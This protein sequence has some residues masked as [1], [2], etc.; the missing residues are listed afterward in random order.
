[1]KTHLVVP[2]ATAMLYACSSCSGVLQAGVLPWSDYN[3]PD[4]P[5]PVYNP[6]PSGYQEELAAPVS[7]LTPPLMQQTNFSQLAEPKASFFPQNQR[8]DPQNFSLDA[9]IVKTIGS[10]EGL[11]QQVTYLRSKNP[12]MREGAGWANLPNNVLLQTALELM[13][14]EHGQSAYALQERFNL[15]EIPSARHAG[16]AQYTG[17]FTP[18]VEV[19]NWPDENYRY[20][21]YSL[22]PGEDCH[23]TRAEIDAGALRGRGLEIGWTND[24]VNLYF[25]HIQGSAIARFSDGQEVFLDYAGTNDKRHVSIGQYLQ[26]QG[27]QGSLSNESIRQW[28]HQHPERITEVLHQ[29]PRYVFF[30]KTENRPKTS[31]G[32]EVIPWHTVA[33]DDN[34]IPLGS[35]LLAEIPRID[36]HG[37]MVGSDWRLLF[38]QDRG[39]AIKGPGRLDFYTGA[40]PQAEKATYHM[41]GFR[42]SYLV[43]LKPEFFKNS[44]AGL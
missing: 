9:C 43:V 22:P 16:Q 24:V 18:V 44:F 20:P 27:Y 38:A 29:N 33:V 31:I 15:M 14:W 41:T 10:Q 12:Q 32:S 35:V 19:Q 8:C 4:S 21:I 1:M 11:L 26:A 34:F 2:V 17:Y 25:S 3:A 6:N 13:R 42:K 36:H 7:Q 28:L 37:E 30:K 5:L 23:F 39:K 40:G